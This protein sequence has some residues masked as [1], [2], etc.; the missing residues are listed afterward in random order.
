VRRRTGC[1]RPLK[2][3]RRAACRDRNP[4]MIQRLLNVSLDVVDTAPPK[5]SHMGVTPTSG[6]ETPAYSPLASPSLAMVFR[7][8]SMAPVY[9]PFSAVCMRTLT[10]SKGWPT[11]TANTPPTP[12]ASSARSDWSEDLEAALTSSLSSAVLGSF[13]MTE[14]VVLGMMGSCSGGA[15]IGGITDCAREARYQD[16]KRCLK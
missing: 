8:T 10:R 5:Y 6:A 1:S 15:S 16:C 7:T 12:P 3:W 9:T 4:R 2:R 11:T 14:S 13:S